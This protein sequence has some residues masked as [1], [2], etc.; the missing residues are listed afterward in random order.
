MGAIAS[1]GPVPAGIGGK[2][3]LVHW[4]NPIVAGFREAE[5]Y[6]I[7]SL[8]SKGEKGISFDLGS[9]GE[10]GQG[11]IVSVGDYFLH[12]DHLLE[13]V[14]GARALESFNLES[15]YP[16]TSLESI[17]SPSADILRNVKSF[18]GEEKNSFDFEG[19]FL[20]RL[21]SLER[22]TLERLNLETLERQSCAVAHVFHRAPT[23]TQL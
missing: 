4:A 13:S 10:D 16:I 23:S 18:L 17:Y 14:S 22:L 19:A 2:G 3:S 1:Q 9:S 5:H 6:F 21:D 20:E 12:D 15:F 7:D 11:E 8:L